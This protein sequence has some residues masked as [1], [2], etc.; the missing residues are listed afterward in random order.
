MITDPPV[1]ADTIASGGD[2]EETGHNVGKLPRQG[3][4]LTTGRPD[5]KKPLLNQERE[6]KNWG[7]Q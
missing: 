1:A 4:R 3:K 5:S 6:M 7:M 2:K